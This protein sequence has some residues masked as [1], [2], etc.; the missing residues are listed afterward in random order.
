MDRTFAVLPT[1]DDRS[2]P[3]RVVWS[4]VGLC[5]LVV[6]GAFV[7]AQ[8]AC[9][10]FTNLDDLTGGDAGQGD[11]EVDAANDS[12][13]DVAVDA[14]PTTITVLQHHVCPHTKP[15][16]KFACGFLSENTAGSAFLIHFYYNYGDT[17]LVTMGVTDNDSNTYTPLDINATSCPAGMLPNDVC[18]TTTAYLGTCQGWAYATN[19]NI[20]P[21]NPATITFTISSPNTPSDVMGA[22][23]FEITG[24]ADSPVDEADAGAMEGND[25]A[26]TAVVTPTITTSAAGDLIVASVAFDRNGGGATMTAPSG[27][28]LD[29]DGFAFAG[30]E[31]EIGGA[32]GSSYG[33]SS[34]GTIAGMVNRGTS[35]IFALKHH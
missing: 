25:G 28:D 24:L 30:A 9:A 27:W 18:C 13:P 31:F 6:L 12:A 33:G 22:D 5:K 3:A 34:M 4:I 1:G 8:G 19:V 14:P 11:A 17:D 21:N 2:G 23:I 15:A 16:D 32:A 29:Q 10:L 20:A 26:P 7:T 35:A